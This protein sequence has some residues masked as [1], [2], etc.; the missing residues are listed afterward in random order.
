MKFKQYIIDSEKCPDG[1]QWCDKKKKCVP[2]GSGDGEGK[3]K[4]KNK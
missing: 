4:R 3:R 2:I 1:E